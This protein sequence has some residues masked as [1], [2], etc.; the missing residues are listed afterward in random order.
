M[1][2]EP[3][4]SP[5][6]RI[7]RNNNMGLVRYVLA[8]GV[9]IAH[10]DLLCGAKIPWIISSYDS[11]CGFFT[12][13]GFLLVFPLLNGKSVKDF[14]VDRCWR[15]LPSYLFV[16]I[17]TALGL[18]LVSTLS[19]G[20]YF[21]SA[22]FWKYL[23]AN[24]SSLNFLHPDLP[25]VFSGRPMEAVNGS[26]WT[27]KIEWQLSLTMPVLIVILTRLKWKLRWAAAAIIAVSLAYRFF[28]G[29]LSDL[30]GREIYAILQ[31]Q[32]FGQLVFFYCG[33]MLYTFYGKIRSNAARAAT[34]AIIAFVLLKAICCDLWIFDIAY[35]FALA[36]VV[37]AIS[38]IPNDL[39]RKI[40]GGHNIS[41]E[42]Y[43]VHFPIFQLL[44]SFGAV[45]KLGAATAFAL[46]LVLSVGAAFVVYMCV[47]HLYLS[48]KK[49]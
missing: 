41:Y 32:L 8:L 38:L 40:D 17:V 4:I 47:G 5:V 35:P 13:S 21:G 15:L 2:S 11:V 43:L 33:V 37:V 30:T 19:F 39:S 7:D 28:F 27:I 20:D 45:E 49:Q 44:A 26:L 42:I 24:I 46:G 23:A 22:G 34:I 6:A 48:R 1:A 29:Y 14:I 25:G 31:R 3:A 18:S 10:F 12:L 9:L 16:V 36:F